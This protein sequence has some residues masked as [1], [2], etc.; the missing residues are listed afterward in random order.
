MKPDGARG[1]AGDRMPRPAQD[2]SERSARRAG[3]ARRRSRRRA[4]RAASRS[5]A[6]RVRARARCCICS[7]GSMRRPAVRCAS[8]A[9]RSRRCPR[10]QR[11]AV[12]NRALGFIYQFH[13]LL[14]EFTALENVAMPLAIR[15]DARRAR[16]SAQANDMLDARRTRASRAR[17][18]RASCR[19]A[20]ASASR[21][22]ARSSRR[23]AACSRTSRPAISTAATAR[24]VF[25]LMLE[26][27]RGRRHEP[28]HRDARSRARR[29]HR[30]H[31][32]SRRRQAAVTRAAGA[33]SW[34]RQWEARVA[35]P[36]KYSTGTGRASATG[37]TSR[38][39]DTAASSRRPRA[40]RRAWGA[41]PSK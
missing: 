36:L 32:A 1:R 26:L 41:A 23:R 34:P 16:R 12:R 13:H 4:R 9:R 25:D 11:G 31:A 20:S 37:T 10:R 7:A 2:I 21:S 3:A 17:I 6:R 8:K 30:S 24:Q 22:R 35:S 15:R 40:T 29:A 18:C 19:A 33:T 27:N 5:S 38:R 28:R 14:P 39:C